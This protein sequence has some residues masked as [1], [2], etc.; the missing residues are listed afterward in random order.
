M[1]KWLSRLKHKPSNAP[2]GKVPKVPEAARNVSNLACLLALPDGRQFW[3]APDG[4][5]FSSGGIPI[6]RRSIMDK[7]VSTDA[8]VKTE[9][10]HLLDAL[11]ELG[12]ELRMSPEVDGAIP[13]E[14]MMQ[15]DRIRAEESK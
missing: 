14:T 12:G 1:N 13:A 11:Y 3:L 10:M 7:I 5:K 2:Y 8:D 15:T 4:M 9:I 6:I